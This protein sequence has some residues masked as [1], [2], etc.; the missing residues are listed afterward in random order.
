MDAALQA[1]LGRST[2]ARFKRSAHDLRGVEQIPALRAL[3]L[4]GAFREGAERAT[5]AAQV[6]VVDVAVDDVSR[7]VAVGFGAQLVGG[8]AYEPKLAAACIEQIGERI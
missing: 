3:M 8:R 2:L 7:D 4:A 1:N 6:G 5:V